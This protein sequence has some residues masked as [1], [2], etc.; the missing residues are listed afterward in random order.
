M[1]QRIRGILNA[2]NFLML[3]YNICRDDLDKASELTP[4]M[5]GPTVS[6]LSRDNWVAVRAMVPRTQAN[7]VMDALSAIGAEAILA[8]QLRIARL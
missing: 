3:D 8:T 1:L 5:T 2:E 6:P 4:G 7:A